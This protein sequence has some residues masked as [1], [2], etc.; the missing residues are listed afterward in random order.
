VTPTTG[1]YHDFSLAAPSQCVFTFCRG[2]GDASFNTW[3]CL[4]DENWNVIRENDDTCGPRSEIVVAL[5]TGTYHLAVSAFD[6]SPGGNYTLAYFLVPERRG[7]IRGDCDGD[8]QVR[9]LVTDAV[10][11]LNFNFLG[12]QRPRCLAACDANADGTVIGV[13]TDAVYLL[14]FNYLGGPRPPDPFPG[15]GAG[16]VRDEAL[17]CVTPPAGCAPG[18]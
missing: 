3:L 14:T 17:G 8:G 15:C 7:F 10:F 4:F 9:G 12:G 6:G 1:G 18:P 13:V 2:G 11:L 5:G 16:T